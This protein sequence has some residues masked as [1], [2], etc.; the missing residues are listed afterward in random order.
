LVI[1]PEV[2]ALHQTFAAELHDGVGT[3]RGSQ[4]S[5]PPDRDD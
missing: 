3:R 1:V 5:A 2:E 4:T